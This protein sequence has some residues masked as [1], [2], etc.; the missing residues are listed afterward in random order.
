MPA[1][2]QKQA[3]ETNGISTPVP[4]LIFAGQCL[5]TLRVSSSGADFP[6]F[7]ELIHCSPDTEASGPKVCPAPERFQLRHRPPAEARE[8]WVD[9]YMGVEE[10]CFLLGLRGH[11]LQQGY[12][13]IHS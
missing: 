3:V 9:T 4:E 6:G 10:P 5:L 13:L 11:E 1:I 7:L 2:R 12:L 8:G